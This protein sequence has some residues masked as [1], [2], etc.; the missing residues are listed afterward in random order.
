MGGIKM[1]TENID[2]FL[3]WTVNCS[4]IEKKEEKKKYFWG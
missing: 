4:W 2:N 1:K 3:K